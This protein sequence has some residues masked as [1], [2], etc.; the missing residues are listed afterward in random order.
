MVVLSAMFIAA[1][2]FVH[3]R[4]WLDV[5]RHVPASTPGAD[6]VRVG[7]PVNA[8]ASLV[9]AFAL[10]AVFRRPSRLT[11]PA[12]FTALA[13]QAASLATLIATR[14]D[15]VLGWS[16]PTWTLGAEQTRAVEAAAIVA[17][18]ALATVSRRD[19]TS[20]HPHLGHFDVVP[21][22]EGASLTVRRA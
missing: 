14:V 8:A 7:F 12:I 22:A 3:L 5:Y 20:V 16:E 21:R 15:S 10:V 19:R 6:L 2:G 13:F 17:L 18:L 9:L 1:G 11:Q 4:E